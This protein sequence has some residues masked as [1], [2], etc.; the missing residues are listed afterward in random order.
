MKWRTKLQNSTGYLN[1]CVFLIMLGSYLH[2]RDKA[3]GIYVYTTTF[4]QYAGYLPKI[5]GFWYHNPL[6]NI[7]QHTI[8][9]FICWRKKNQIFNVVTF[10]EKYALL[11]HKCIDKGKSNQEKLSK[12]KP[13]FIMRRC[14]NQLSNLSNEFLKQNEKCNH[15]TMSE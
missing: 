1:P 6:L 15:C 7:I 13:L 9:V 12:R 11:S 10:I 4:E 14:F 3:F 5:S 2:R 8:L